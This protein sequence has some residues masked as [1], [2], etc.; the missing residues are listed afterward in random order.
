G[1]MSRK[2]TLKSLTLSDH[3]IAVVGANAVARHTWASESELD[4][5]A[6]SIRIN[7][8][9]VWL[10]QGGSWKLLARQAVRPDQPACSERDAPRGPVRG[11]PSPPPP[12]GTPPP[13]WPTSSLPRRATRSETGAPGYAPIASRRSA[14]AK[15]R[16]R[17]TSMLRWRRRS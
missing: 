9:Q 4:G 6:T 2:A 16:L 14:C 15:A 1:V 11:G 10:Q 3:T 17:A 7:V 13:R 8:L 5:K 12:A